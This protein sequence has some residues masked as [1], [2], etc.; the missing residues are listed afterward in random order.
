MV[1]V[2]RTT[3]ALLF[4]LATACSTAVPSAHDGHAHNDYL[5]PHPLLD[6][7]ANGF[8]SA[9]ADV[10]LVDG[11]LRVGHER[12]HLLDGTLQSH[13][14]EPLRER[15][16]AGGGRVLPDGRTFTLL[17]DIK[18]DAPA[19]Y[20]ALR[21]LF[22]DYR[23]LLTV[24]RDD[25][26]TAGAV[27]VILSGE[28]PRELVAAERERMC[29]IDGRPEDLDTGPSPF[30]VPWISDAWRNH[31][32]ARSCDLDA[33]QRDHLRTLVA[34]AHAQGRK[35]RFWGAPDDPAAW[36]LQRDAGVDLVHTDRLTDY[37]AWARR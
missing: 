2:N 12:D 36:T 9:E 34:R 13:Y 16:R 15:A 19:V 22:A 35:L 5:H 37:A 31:F 24:F 27:T 11:E 26:A 21:P 20:A 3:W 6:A 14:L 1:E 32:P 7:L 8:A 17:V 33:A 29:A 25:G 10:F 30:L 18:A 23:D 28:R 4:A